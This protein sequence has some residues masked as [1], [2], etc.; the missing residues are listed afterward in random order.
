M[1]TERE[2]Q[3]NPIVQ[4]S[5][6]H[7]TKVR[8]VPAPTPMPSLLSAQ[9]LRFFS[10]SYLIYFPALR[11]KPKLVRLLGPIISSPPHL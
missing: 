8:P 4:E 2:L 1:L 3:I 11:T 5:V 9:S 6:L 10:S 7:N